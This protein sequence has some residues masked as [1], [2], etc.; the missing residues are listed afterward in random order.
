M[1]TQAQ[2]FEWTV[3]KSHWCPA[4]NADVALL[5]RRV[6]PQADFIDTDTFRVVEQRCSHDIQCN[7][8]DHV[9]CKWSGTNPLYDPF[10]ES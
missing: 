6:Y 2:Q 8:N 1:K 4:A 10:A 9:H 5:E 3:V 7:L